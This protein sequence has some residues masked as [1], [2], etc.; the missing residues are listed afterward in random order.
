MPYTGVLTVLK[1]NKV[2]ALYGYGLYR[3]S[4]GA[5]TKKSYGLYIVMALYSYGLCRSSHGAQTKKV[6]AY[7]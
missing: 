6:M 3:S 5:Q 7:I 1:I 2:M 4:H